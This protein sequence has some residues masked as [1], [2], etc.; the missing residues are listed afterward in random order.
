MI[1]YSQRTYH[2]ALI[3]NTYY[4]FTI[5]WILIHNLWTVV[6]KLW[7]FVQRLWTRFTNGYKRFWN[8]GKMIF[9]PVF[10]EFSARNYLL[11]PKYFLFLW[12]PC[13]VPTGTSSTSTRF[14]ASIPWQSIDVP[15]T[16]SGQIADGKDRTLGQIAQKNGMFR[17][18]ERPKEAFITWKN[19]R[20]RAK[21]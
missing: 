20:D 5:L 10:T 21:M 11:F 19:G 6:R 1:L 18:K 13:K 2:K 3:I 16:N 14:Y 4:S 12:K 9:L 8:V 15:K 7:I 17:T